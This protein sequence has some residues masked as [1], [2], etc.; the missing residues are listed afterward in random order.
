MFK[1]PVDT[2]WTNKSLVSV[3]GIAEWGG[4][5]TVVQNT[6]LQLFSEIMNLTVNFKYD[7]AVAIIE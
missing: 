1:D 4:K 2:P 6:G 7:H 3:P 5:G